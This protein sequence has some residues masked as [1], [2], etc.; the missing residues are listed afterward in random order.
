MV[1]DLNHLFLCFSGLVDSIK[2][3]LGQFRVVYDQNQVFRY[4]V[5]LVECVKLVLGQFAVVLGRESGFCVIF[6]DT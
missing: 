4:L 6:D 1:Q 3:V 5:L 2:P